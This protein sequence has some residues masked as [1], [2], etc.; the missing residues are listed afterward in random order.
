MQQVLILLTPAFLI[1]HISFCAYRLDQKLFQVGLKIWQ[2]IVYYPSQASASLLLTCLSPGHRLTEPSLRSVYR[3]VCLAA[4]QF[5]FLASLAKRGLLSRIQVFAA[6]PARQALLNYHAM[7]SVTLFISFHPYQ[8]CQ[9]S[10]HLPH[11]L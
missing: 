8:F 9:I 4:T 5:S 10:N 2:R 11:L 1:S 6:I 7:Q 3:D